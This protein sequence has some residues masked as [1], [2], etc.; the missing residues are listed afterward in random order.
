MEEALPPVAVA[1]QQLFEEELAEVAFPDVDRASLR[2]HLEEAKGAAE[3]V[4]LLERELGQA[5]TAAQTLAD[6]ARSHAQRGLAYARIYAEAHPDLAVK[7][8]SME[9]LR[10]P[11]RRTTELAESGRMELPP[12]EVTSSPRRRGRPPKSAGGLAPLFPASVRA[13]APPDPKRLELPPV[14]TREL[15]IEADEP[16]P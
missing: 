1:L 13:V 16:A 11:R 12:S 10:G 7:L 6:R 3:R 15:V 14:A 9:A 5:R 4:A 8:E 2:R